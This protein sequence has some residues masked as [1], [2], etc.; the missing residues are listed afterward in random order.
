MVKAEALESILAAVN[1]ISELPLNIGDLRKLR[2]I[3][4]RRN[5]RLKGL[6]QSL[7]KLEDL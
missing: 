1:N 3:D 2:V 6:P 4:L 7:E 5:K